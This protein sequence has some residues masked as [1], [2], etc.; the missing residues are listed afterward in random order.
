M[1]TGEKMSKIRAW[2]DDRGKPYSSIDG[3]LHVRR[4]LKQLFIKFLNGEY[5]VDGKPYKSQKTVI[6]EVLNP[7]Y[8]SYYKEV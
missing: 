4:G 2:L 8:G 5:I 3:I 6:N 1:K 7:F